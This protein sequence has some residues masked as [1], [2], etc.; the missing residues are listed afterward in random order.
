LRDRAAGYDVAHVHAG[1]D[2]VSIGAL[3]VLSGAATPLLT[4]THGMII[5]DRRWAVRALDAALVR[6]LLR[7]A[8]VHLVLTDDEERQL[9]LV[10]GGGAALRRIINGVP[11]TTPPPPRRSEPPE[12]LFCARLDERKRPA[13]FVEMAALVC[14]GGVAAR[15]A[16]VG[17]DEGCLALVERRIRELGL[18]DAVTYEGPLPY[19]DVPARLARASVFVLPSAEEPFPMTLLEAMSL[20]VPSVCTTSCGLAGQ[21]A[22]ERAVIVTEGSPAALAEAVS[23]LL[24]DPVS[25]EAVAARGRALASSVF[26]VH[27][28]VDALEDCY[29][30]LRADAGSV[31]RGE[32]AGDRG[33]S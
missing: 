29:D 10:I 8:G 18:R 21:L 30:G 25:R 6:P 23:G 1:R 13:A 7:R 22:A 33:A 28:V 2:L 31:P 11:V 14:R 12:V 15:F 3:A 26:S 19:E 4:Q 17:P 16:M 32:V 20:G 9:P 27:H 5:P 24:R